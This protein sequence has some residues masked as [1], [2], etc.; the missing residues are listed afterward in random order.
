MPVFDVLVKIFKTQVHE[1]PGG[2]GC[3]VSEIKR[4]SARTRVKKGVDRC[5]D[6]CNQEFN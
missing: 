2:N 4:R 3:F 5:V 6:R 1:N